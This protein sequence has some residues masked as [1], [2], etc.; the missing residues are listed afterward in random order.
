M[1]LPKPLS[2]WQTIMTAFPEDLAISIKKLVKQVSPLIDNVQSQHNLGET[3]PCGFGGV[4]REVNYNRLLLSEWGL[5]EQYP[6]EFIRRAAMGEHLFLDSLW[7]VGSES[8]Y[9][10]G[11]FDCGPEQLGKP[12]LVQLAILIL[13]ARRAEK[14]K[15]IFKWGVL[16]D[17][18]KRWKTGLYK[19]DI[20]A[21][22]KQRS[23][24]LADQELLEDWFNAVDFDQDSVPHRAYDLWLITKAQFEVA[25]GAFRR[26]VIEEP[27]LGPDNI[28]VTVRYKKTSRSVLLRLAD[29]VTNVKIIRNPFSRKE[30]VQISSKWDMDGFWVTSKNGRKMVC[31]AGSNKIVLHKVIDQPNRC[32]ISQK[33]QFDIPEDQTCIGVH[34]SKKRTYLLCSDKSNFYLYNIHSTDDSVKKINRLQAIRTNNTQLLNIIYTSDHLD[35]YKLLL[36][37]SRGL[38][39]SLNLEDKQPLFK[40]EDRNVIALGENTTCDYYARYNK[41][42]NKVDIFWYL[43]NYLPCKKS[44]IIEFSGDSPRI[45][46]H[47]TGPWRKG[48][49]GCVAIENDNNVWQLISGNITIERQLDPAIYVI[50]TMWMHNKQI[51]YHGAGKS[52]Q[53]LIGLDE[54]RQSIYACYED[55]EVKLLDLSLA[56]T[57]AELN[58]RLPYLHY[59]NYLN[60]LIVVNL[61]SGNELYRIAPE[62]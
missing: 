31:R 53:V 57:K 29:E 14:N 32:N 34:V 58:P 12:R 36:L 21:W 38:L 23:A 4:S 28:K 40:T 8:Q 24:F 59:V 26:V 30:K 22:L 61:N 62:S 16:Q 60:E 44:C 55:D 42:H 37:D 54:N 2:H 6:D 41:K 9:C 35:T 33:R 56:I 19:E 27:L 20:Q 52:R 25:S 39:R 17:D 11:L 50:G 18:K 1:E 43:S 49:I 51:D 45:F 7:E 15:L 10:Y 13:L 48:S 47:G 5:Q 46:F 3:E